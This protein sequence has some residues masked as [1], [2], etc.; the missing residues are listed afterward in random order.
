MNQIR[1]VLRNH[2]A[3][4]T[5]VE[6]NEDGQWKSY[7]NSKFYIPDSHGFSTGYLTFLNCLKQNY[8]VVETKN[9]R[10]V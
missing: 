1:W 5:T 10:D 3:G 7:K 4:D 2:E 9:M 6:V 8:K